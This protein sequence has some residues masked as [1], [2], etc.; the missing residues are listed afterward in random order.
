MWFRADRLTLLASEFSPIRPG[1]NQILGLLAFALAAGGAERR[2]TV[3]CTHLRAAKTAEGEQIRAAQV[4]ALL[5][6]LAAFAQDNA[7]PATILAGL[8]SAD[9]SRPS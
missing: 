2:V 3:G 6:R 9:S 7:A 4:D 5:P 1:D 8:P